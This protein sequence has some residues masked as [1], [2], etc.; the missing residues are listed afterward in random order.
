[1]ISVEVQN[2]VTG[3]RFAQ[4]SARAFIGIFLFNHLFARIANG[5]SL[6]TH[7]IRWNAFALAAKLKPKFIE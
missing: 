5:L 4:H 6:I 3:Q 1:M 2:R 7:S